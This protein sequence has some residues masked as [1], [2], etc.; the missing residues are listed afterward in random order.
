MVMKNPL[1][2]RAIRRRKNSKPTKYIIPRKKSKGGTYVR[3]QDYSHFEGHIIP[4]IAKGLSPLPVICWYND[5]MISLPACAVR[6][7]WQQ[8]SYCKR[9]S[10]FQGD[11]YSKELRSLIENWE[12]DDLEV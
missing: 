7:F 1:R 12:K 4:D 8:Q 5:H 6:K 9:C 11:E 3:T 10:L 2:R